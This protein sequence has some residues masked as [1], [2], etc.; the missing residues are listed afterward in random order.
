MAV[1]AR[2]DPDTK[3]QGYGVG[4]GG[5]SHEKGWVGGF[6]EVSV[7]RGHL[8]SEGSVREAQGVGGGSRQERAWH[9]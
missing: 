7:I 4:V 5:T 8:R 2:R 3:V 6:E 1:D 9:V